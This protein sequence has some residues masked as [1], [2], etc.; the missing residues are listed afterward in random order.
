MD[1]I[2]AAILNVKLK[3]LDKYAKARQEAAYYYNKIFE[4]NSNIEI[5]F[6]NPKSTHVYHQYTIK[7]KNINRDDLKEFLNKKNIPAMIYYPVPLHLQ[8]AYLYLGY[9]KGDFPVSEKLSDEV[10]SLPMHTELDEEQLEYIT[11]N[12]LAHVGE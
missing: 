8:E 7:L 1:S 9:K 12:I 5:P 4:G 11:K 2:Q 10:L 6:V 3:Y